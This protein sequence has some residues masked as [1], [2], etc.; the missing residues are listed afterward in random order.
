MH[1]AALVV[2]HRLAHVRGLPVEH[3]REAVDDGAGAGVVHLGQHHETRGA[4]DQ[5]ADRGAVA[6]ALDKVALPVAGDEAVLDLWRADMDALH[7]FDLTTPVHSRAARFADLVVVAQAGDQLA[8]EFATRVQID[9][10]ADRLVRD[11]FVRVV[12]PH[13]TQYVRNLLGRPEFLQIVPHHLEKR[14]IGMEFR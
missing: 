2:G 13:G 11:R 3:R 4:F 7:I 14:A 1:L 10:V 5:C 9:R 8:F 12:G 6:F